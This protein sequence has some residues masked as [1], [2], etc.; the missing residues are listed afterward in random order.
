MPR[1]CATCRHPDRADID[2]SLVGGEPNRRVAARFALSEAS[3]RRHRAD[4]LPAALTQARAAA[5]VAS[6][7]TLLDRLRSLNRE[8]ADVL[9]AAKVARGHDLRL[10]AIAR[11]EK[12]IELEGRLLGELID[13]PTVN[14]AVL[15]EWLGLRAAVLRALAPFPAARLAVA[16]ALAEGEPRA[17]G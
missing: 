2:A 6:A 4:H 17:D 3:V 5:E 11:A 12:Q 13:A 16:A 14:V 9:R 8:T 1:P 15:P 7:D 10:R